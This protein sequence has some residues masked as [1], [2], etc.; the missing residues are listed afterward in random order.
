MNT[1]PHVWMAFVAML[2]AVGTAAAEPALTEDNSWAFTPAEDPYSDEA[3]LDLSHLNEDVAGET[4]FVRVAE[5]GSFIRGDGEPIRFWSVISRVDFR[6][7]NMSAEEIDQFYRFLAKRGVNMVRLF[8]TLEMAEEG[9]E[10]TDYDRGQVEAIWRAVAIGK[11]HGVYSIICP[12]WAHFTVPESWGLAGGEQ[13]PTGLLFFNPTLQDAYKEWVRELYTAPN[14]YT[15]IPL[16]DDPAVAI[17]QIQ[18][19]DSMFFWTTQGLH[20]EQRRIL[21]RQFGDWLVEKHGSLEAA[22]EA[23]DGQSEPDDDL[24]AGIV[25]MI[26]PPSMIWH[27]TQDLSGGRALRMRDQTEFLARLQH[28]FYADMAD[29]LRNEMGCRQ[30]INASNWRTGSQLRLEDLE[31]WS[32][33]AVDVGALN[34]YSTGIHS[35][36]N[37]GYRIDPGHYIVNRSIL[38]NPLQVPTNVRQNLGEPFVLTEAAWVTPNFYQTEGPMLMAAYMGLTGVDSACWFDAS[39][40]T[41]QLDPRRT[42]WPVVEGETGYALGKWTGMIPTQ[43][44][45]FPANALMHR[46]GYVQQGEPAVHEARPLEHIFERREPIIAEAESFDPIRDTQD[47][48][49]AT[50]VD[51]AEVSRLAFLVGPV[52]VEYGG[53]PEDTRVID[54]APY[55]DGEAEVVRSNTGELELRYG[56]GVF[57]LDAPKAQG[58]TGFLS[59]AGGRFELGDVEIRS[60]NDYATIQLVS[61][62]GLPLA[63]SRQV[64]VQV[65]TVARLTGWETEPATFERGDAVVEGLRIERTGMPPWRIKNTRAAVSIANPNLSRATLLDADGYPDRQVS[66]STE[67]GRLSVE[68]PE[69]TMYMVLE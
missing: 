6:I 52:H 4:G 2:L 30:L 50:G 8:A 20:P 18:N 35:G 69:D 43:V 23:W 3:V 40:Y 44:G 7:Q 24:E 37:A 31:R 68:L 58:V 17:L 62:D 61:M 19:E 29:Y 16:K 54:L 49:G 1:Y 59:E 38:R 33:S 12:Y 42:F 41:W 34:R 14:P 5:D 55:I 57:T 15:G 39:H 21:H 67:D 47:L 9:A 63:E 65:G 45:M 36:P 60:E 53:D 25:S 28:D 46:M 10:I 26:D 48:R 22:I 66:V 51:V 27:M 11:E 56:V 13:S 32:Y 64:L